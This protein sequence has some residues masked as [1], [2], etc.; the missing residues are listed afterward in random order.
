M[1]KK[2]TYSICI[3]GGCPDAEKLLY[4]FGQTKGIALQIGSQCATAEYAMSVC[5][6]HDEL[7]LLQEKSSS[8]FRDALRKIH[9]IHVLL[10]S[11]GLTINEL[12]ITINGTMKVYDA[13]F[14]GF[15]FIT[16]LLQG[17]EIVVPDKAETLVSHLL[18]LPHSKLSIDYRVAALY[19]F[20]ASSA[21]DFQ[22]DRFTN[23]WT[24]MNACYN[25]TSHMYT[26]SMSARYHIT[27]EQKLNSNLALKA[28]G[29]CIGAFSWLIYP[30]Y[31][32]ITAELA[33]ELKY[34]YLY[35][36]RELSKLSN[37]EVALL[38]SQA[39]ANIESGCELDSRFS[40]LEQ[41]ISYFGVPVYTCLLLGYPYY[42][43]CKFI[44][45]NIAT[46]L[47]EFRTDADHRSLEISCYFMEQY[48]KEHIVEMFSEGYWTEQKT[49]LVLDF[50]ANTNSDA[51]NAISKNKV[52]Q[53]KKKK[54]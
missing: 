31:K 14:P 6:T 25:Y 20:L 23:L 38:Y 11:C 10:F 24:A 1:K 9:L 51:A 46:T 19:A 2:T 32:E 34:H 49:D 15:P 37:E 47:F 7:V 52:V 4:N 42:L 48:L 39:K 27:E 35:I 21:R 54:K 16:S 50:F 43:R 17:R 45:G 33:D 26:Q 13:S 8:V 18:S 41:E 36:S 3:N 44:H 40:V 22:I 53:P 30:Q 5:K 28:D 29:K 12:S